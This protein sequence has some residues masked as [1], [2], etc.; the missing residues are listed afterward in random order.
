M[1]SIISV[2]GLLLGAVGWFVVRYV[3]GGFYTVA[4]N[5]RAVKTSFGKAEQLQTTTLDNPMSESLRPEERERYKYP[6]VRVIPPGG[7]YFKW[8]W[9]KIYKASVATETVNMAWDPEDAN[10]NR[11]GTMLE[12]VTKDQLNTGLV[13][14]LRFRVNEQNLYAYLFAVKRP[15][16]HVMGYFIS[17]LRQRISA[18]EAPKSDVPVGIVNPL[19]ISVVSGVSINDLRKNLRILNETMDRD[20][21]SSSARYGIQLDAALI[22]DIDPPVEVES[23]LAAINTAHNHVSSDISLAQASADQ[24]LVQSRRA[25]EVETLNA[26]AE[27]EPLV[28]MA[29]QLVELKKMGPDVLKAYTRNVRLSLFAKAKQAM[30]EVKR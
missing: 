19:E 21:M 18:F 29:T 4:P 9:E 12:A 27:V 10:A 28:S 11:G 6:Q 23:A 16:V 26:Q 5:E 13:G 8:P 22:T 17:I 1:D 24:R 7:P 25:V 15:I 30:L 2:P 3:L 14:Q 20:C